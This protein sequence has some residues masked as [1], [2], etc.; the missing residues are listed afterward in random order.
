MKKTG[1]IFVVMVL[2]LALLP[3]GNAEAKTQKCKLSAT[4]KTMTVGKKSTIRLKKAGKVKWK[5]DKKAV[6]DVK[7]KAGGKAVLYAKKKGKATVTAV[8]KGKKYRCR[9]TVK[10]KKKQSKADESSSAQADKPVLNA[11]EISLYYR[12]DTYSDILPADSS[13]Q[14]TFRFRVSGTKKEVKKWELL[15]EDV[16]CFTITQY[17][18]VTMLYGKIYGE[19]DAVVTV[20]ATL[21]D[22]KV[23]TAEIKGYNET[24]LYLDTLFQKFADENITSGMTEKEK[25]DRVAAYIGEISRYDLYNYD[26]REIFLRGRGD[27]MASRYAVEA[28]CRYIGIK[29]QG[30]ASNKEHGR[31]VVQADGKYY[32]YTT[33]YDEPVPRSYT[34]TET[35]Y[36]KLADSAKELGIWMGYFD[37]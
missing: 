1:W 23:L 6:V 33:G 18:K 15:G 28:L 2:F 3:T 25:A 34:V 9:V 24:N 12:S 19:P 26:W 27:C 11:K 8:Y 14:N 22:G 20:K 37:R 30:C 36:E 16:W 31:T 17:G 10:A 5:S 13:H 7:K 21:T 32:I 4:K 29:A 35:T